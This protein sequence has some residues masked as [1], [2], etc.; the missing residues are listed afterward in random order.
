MLQLWL[1]S[2]VGIVSIAIATEAHWYCISLS[3]LTH[4]TVREHYSENWNCFNRCPEQ[5]TFVQFATLFPQFLVPQKFLHRHHQIWVS[6]LTPGRD[7]CSDILCVVN[8]AWQLMTQMFTFSASAASA[9]SYVTTDV[10]R[11][12]I[13]TC[14]PLSSFHQCHH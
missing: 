12:M 9:Q 11:K 5:N 13:Q 1:V 4:Q 14:T 8:I 3:H 10:E 7:L 6:P 2:L